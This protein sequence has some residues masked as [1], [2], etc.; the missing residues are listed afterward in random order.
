M[1]REDMYPT[2][3]CFVSLF[4][5]IDVFSNSVSRDNSSSFLGKFYV[6][7]QLQM[8][9]RSIGADLNVITIYVYPV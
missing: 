7:I 5:I 3:S 2:K 6:I 9:K 4:I 1:K 8:F